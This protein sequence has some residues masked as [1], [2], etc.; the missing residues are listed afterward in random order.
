M[1]A[2]YSPWVSEI[3]YANE[4]TE[5]VFCG[6]ELIAQAEFSSVAV[7]IEPNW[8]AIRAGHQLCRLVRVRDKQPIT[9]H[10]NKRLSISSVNLL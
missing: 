7:A 9:D 8:T 5:V 4:P 2:R 6:N 3:E 1:Q 10:V